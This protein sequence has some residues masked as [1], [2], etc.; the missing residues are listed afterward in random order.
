[1]A[2]V[3]D[4]I[5]EHADA[6]A[7]AGPENEEL[8]RLTDDT[9]RRLRE[10]GVIRMLQP[11]THGGTESH[12]REFA[13]A[14]MSLAA[15]DGS[16]GW[17]A[18]VVGVHPWELALADEDTQK[19]V[20]GEDPDT[21]MASPYAPMGMAVPTEGGYVFNGHWQFSSG[22]DHCDWI[23]LG[24][25]RG[26]EEGQMVMPPQNMHMILP[27]SDYEIVDDSWDTAGLRGTGS[28]DV[29]VR[30]AF[31]PEER[32]LLASEVYD[33]TL[34]TKRG[35]DNPL[36]H[37]PFWIMFP[38]G[39]TSAVIGMAEGAL[40]HHLDYQRGRTQITGTKV[41]DDPY[42]L[43]VL[44]EQSANIDAA[45][46]I[47]L[48]SIDR[49]YDRVAAG[50]PIGFHD[51]VQ[52]RKLQTHAAW[53]AARAVF[54]IMTRSGGN[55]MRRSNPIQRFWR[56]ATIGLNH[57]IHVPGTVNHVAGLSQLGLEP[58]P[59]PMIATF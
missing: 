52:H 33:G 46:T 55:A 14:V 13:E 22:T 8:G 57:A 53:L 19:A 2:D 7:A 25:F 28:K 30:D 24:A 54:E 35:L 51:R 1:M 3:Q 47:L 34:A 21:W 36:Y 37:L 18:G 31:V 27:R 43:S 16:T 45:R 15:L 39:I 17:V 9:V 42:V 50:E 44:G 26:D 56:D 38:L 6:I 29:I 4:R 10:I 59:G 48:D 49:V 11:A 41:K 32:G 58:P 12:P 20:W 40:R 5:A 23:F